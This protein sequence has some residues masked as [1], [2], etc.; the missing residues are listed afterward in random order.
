MPILSTGASTN[1]GSENSERGYVF[2]CNN[3]TQQECISQNLFGAERWKLGEMQQYI[4]PG[5]QILL[6]N[7]ESATLM[8]TFVAQGDPKLSI[9]PNAFGGRFPAQLSVKVLEKLVEVRLNFR[10][11]EQ[12]WVS[13]DTWSALQQHLKRAMVTD[14]NA[15]MTPQVPLTLRKTNDVAKANWPDLVK[16]NDVINMSG[17]G[18]D[19]KELHQW[20]IWFKDHLRKLRAKSEC[21][22]FKEINF[23]SNQLTMSGLTLLFRTLL[24]CNLAIG[25]MNYED[26]AFQIGDKVDFTLCDGKLHGRQSKRC[27]AHIAGCTCGRN[28]EVFISQASLEKLWDEQLQMDTR[29]FAIEMCD[30]G[31][32]DKA[33][34]QWASWFLA[35]CRGL[36]QS[37]GCLKV[38]V[39]DFSLNHITQAGLQVLLNALMDARI[40]VERLKIHH[41]MIEMEDGGMIARF[42]QFNEGELHQLQV[43]HNKLSTD[44]VLDIITSI[45]TMN[46]STCCYPVMGS[47]PLWLRVERTGY[48]SKELEKRLRV[49]LVKMHQDFD[50]T[51]CVC[52][53]S[54]TCSPWRCDRLCNPPAI[55]AMY[56]FPH[57]ERCAMQASVRTH[58]V[59]NICPRVTYEEFKDAL[60][61]MRSLQQKLH[62]Q[63][64]VYRQPLRDLHSKSLLPQPRECVGFRR[65]KPRWMESFTSAPQPWKKDHCFLPQQFFRYADLSNYVTASALRAE[66][67]LVGPNNSIAH[68]IRTCH[69]PLQTQRLIRI[70]VAHAQASFVVTADHRLQIGGANGQIRTQEAGDVQREFAKGRGP[71]IYD[72]KHFYSIK[73]AEPFSQ[74]TVVVKVHFKNDAIALAF[75]RPRRLRC[76]SVDL[77]GIAVFGEQQ[78]VACRVVRTFVDT[79]D[80]SLQPRRRSSSAGALPDPFSRWSVG[81]VHHPNCEVCD[82]HN[83]FLAASVNRND[84]AQYKPCPKGALCGRCHELH[85]RQ[86][87]HVMRTRGH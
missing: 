14:P 75:I 46:R 72:G 76:R 81:T 11:I 9:I 22:V 19:D 21:V 82:R 38:K 84:L 56:L 28:C 8:G 78:T 67:A 12:G 68:V 49:E 40:Y 42:I 71:Q 39:V 29:P 33:M 31:I 58:S 1:H 6:F 15:E 24:E 26:N 62:P 61:S 32:D 17:L 52:S 64:Q 4:K 27:P 85:D 69:L 83:Q 57:W 66:D 20:C 44:A 53:H 35:K 65:P 7:F 54:T 47:L 50:K 60:S 45:L 87:G 37:S 77:P 36:S 63:F 23:S 3:T 10:R 34:S 18:M 5:I 2:L 43:S 86:G 30:Q 79:V 55:H 70:R 48:N 80:E 13:I 16:V 73:D 25:R 59:S 74:K 51:L 41:N